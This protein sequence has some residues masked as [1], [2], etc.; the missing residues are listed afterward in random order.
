MPKKNT[1]LKPKVKARLES[2]ANEFGSV[3]IY[4]KKGRFGKKFILKQKTYTFGR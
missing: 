2:N 4:S 1:K 3:I